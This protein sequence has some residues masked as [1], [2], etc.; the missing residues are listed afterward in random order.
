MKKN[1][2]ILLFSV[3]PIVAILL[4]GCGSSTSF[5]PK[6]G[7]VEAEI[8]KYSDCGGFTDRNSSFAED[9]TYIEYDLDKKNET[10]VI[11]HY[12]V[13]RACETND[14]R[15]IQ[16]TSWGSTITIEYR[17]PD[18]ECLCQRDIKTKLKFKK[19]KRDHRKYP[20]RIW[21]HY[22]KSPDPEISFEIDIDKNSTDIVS[23]AKTS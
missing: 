11:T 12:N 21:G 20:I 3:S 7:D 14:T 18:Y 16:D 4:Y 19:L 9:R 6:C 13:S 5:G 23:F 2:L 15:Y 10:L 8:L 17:L 22:T 1:L